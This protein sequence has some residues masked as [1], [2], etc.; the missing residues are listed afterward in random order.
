[1]STMTAMASSNECKAKICEPICICKPAKRTF[2]ASSTSFTHLNAKS[3]NMVK[4]N[5]ESSQPVRIYS[6]V[7]A[8]TPG[9]MRMYTSCTMPRSP[10]KRFTRSSSIRESS[11][12]RPTPASSASH[13][14]CS[15]L[16]L[17]CTNTRSM[18]KPAARAIASSPPPET[19]RHRPLSA[20][21]CSTALFRN[22][23]L[24][25]STSEFRCCTRMAFR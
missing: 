23:L 13:N 3:P 19:S 22:A 18:G 16:L 6:C 5:F 21:I 2:G 25:Y 24:A 7:S 8:S 17:P 20:T 15:V 12:M 11:T 10:A 14:S 9:V 1:M 4:P